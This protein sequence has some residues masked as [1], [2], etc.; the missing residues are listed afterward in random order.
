MG[1]G[2]GRAHWGFG[3]PIR[4]CGPGMQRDVGP[5]E[6]GNSECGWDSHDLFIVSMSV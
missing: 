2:G 3:P 4:P 1:G 6:R 5:E